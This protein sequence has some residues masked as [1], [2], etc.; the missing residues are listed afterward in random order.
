MV[1]TPSKQTK[2]GRVLSFQDGLNDII[3]HHP[4][5]SEPQDIAV[6]DK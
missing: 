6:V 4:G 3:K 5:F 1:E 2:N